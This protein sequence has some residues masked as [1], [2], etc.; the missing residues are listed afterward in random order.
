MNFGPKPNWPHNFAFQE[1]R[2]S[3]LV[4]RLARIPLNRLKENSLGTVNFTDP[5][6]L[7]KYRH[8]MCLSQKCE[9]LFGGGRWAFRFVSLS[10]CHGRLIAFRWYLPVS[11]PYLLRRTPF[12][13]LLLRGGSCMCTSAFPQV[14]PRRFFD[15]SLCLRLFRLLLSSVSSFRYPFSILRFVYGVFLV[16]K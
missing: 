1:I 15:S 6:F 14:P 9:L 10:L 11:I 3:S 4:F 8:L 7:S 16:N 2:W 12:C 5:P 13:L